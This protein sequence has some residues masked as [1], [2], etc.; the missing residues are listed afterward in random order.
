MPSHSRSQR[1]RT[2]R[3]GE[4]SWYTQTANGA[5]VPKRTVPLAEEYRAAWSA[6]NRLGATPHARRAAEALGEELA[7]QS[8]AAQVERGVCVH[9]YRAAHEPGGGPGGRRL[10]PSDPLARP[11]A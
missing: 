4:R 6:F 7:T 2:R 11:T 3:P 9:R 8:L 1:R 10:G 5:G